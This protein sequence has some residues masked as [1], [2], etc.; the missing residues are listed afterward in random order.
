M[1]YLQIEVKKEEKIKDD[2][3]PQVHEFMIDDRYT[4]FLEPISRAIENGLCKEGP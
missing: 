3:L 1:R 2:K 4:I